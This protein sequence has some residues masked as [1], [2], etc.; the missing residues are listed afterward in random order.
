MPVAT[1]DTEGTR[2]PLT[3][4]RVVQAAV[5][6]ADGAGLEGLTMRHVAKALNVAPMAL[7]RHV[8]NREDLIDAMIDVVFSE[9]AL[10]LGGA[11]WKP[12]MRERALS[13]RDALARHRWAIGLMESRLR[14]GPANLRHHD[15]VIGKL[16][17]AGFD[18]A[19][20]AHA[21]SLLDGYIYGFA[22]TRMN[23][24]FDTNAD[25][26]AMAQH[27]FEPFPANEYPNLAEFVNTH[28]LKPGYDYTEEFEYGLEVILD[29]LEA[30]LGTD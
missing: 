11:G 3:R 21:Y 20:V 7:Y 14:P 5:Q 9:I 29:G 23:M 2:T 22:L 15:A 10:P 19:M 16:R 13:L 1:S 24:P 28:V 30:A 18:I 27:M 4:E 17:S 12:A 8:A 6:H 25:M 26:D